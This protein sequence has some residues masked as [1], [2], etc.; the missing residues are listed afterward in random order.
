MVIRIMIAPSA[1]RRLMS[2]KVNGGSCIVY[3]PNIWYSIRVVFQFGL[4]S[5]FW[6]VMAF[7]VAFANTHA[8]ALLRRHPT[9]SCVLGSFLVS[10]Q[11]SLSMLP[12]ISS[13]IVLFWIWISAVSAISMSSMRSSGSFLC[14]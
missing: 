14:T 11:T 5:S 1:N 4:C 10:W 12:V 9:D 8:T 3:S 6:I 13:I 2:E 7:P